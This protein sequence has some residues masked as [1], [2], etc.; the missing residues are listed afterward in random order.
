MGLLKQKNTQQSDLGSVVLNSER[1]MLAPVSRAFAENIFKEF[2]ADI[3]RYMVAK[4]CR[5]Y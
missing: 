4:T 1:L 3:T 5:A 2:T